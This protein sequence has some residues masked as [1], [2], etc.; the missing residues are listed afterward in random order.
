[1]S[2]PV[3]RVASVP[4]A[5]IAPF[6]AP[7]RPAQ[8]GGAQSVVA[9]LGRALSEAGEDVEVIASARSRVAG[10]PLHR[11][12]CG[13]FPTATLRFTADGRAA[14]ERGNDVDPQEIAFDSAVARMR[15]RGGLYHSH[16]FDAAAFAVPSRRGVFALHTL[17]LGPID[18]GVVAAAVAASRSAAPAR[19]VAV[20]ASV[21]EAW[22]THL[23]IAAVVPNGADPDRIPAGGGR[24]R[25]RAVVAGRISREKGTDV[26]IAAA[27]RAG[28]RVLLVGDVYDDD[29]WKEVVAPLVDGDS[30]RHLSARARSQLYRIIGA[31]AVSICAPRWDEPFGMVAL[32]SAMTGTPVA[33]LARGGLREL[34]G[35]SSGRLADGTDADALA[36]A[37]T[38]AAGLDR[39]L[40]RADV[41]QRYSM[42]AMV[43]RYRAVYAGM[44]V[45]PPAPQ[46]TR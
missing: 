19:L 13:P 16:A 41:V 33:A 3:H 34:V 1:M 17:H 29:Y 28:M 9:D 39:T 2:A 45:L 18:S 6:V 27:L 46:E 40:V 11:I 37:V 38:A 12:D 24:H 32:E 7:L 5:L 8:V 20:S 21:A 42:E 26:A 10:V 25:D 15:Q 31:S 35:P 4:I 23:D 14:G 36:V 30:V 43:A 44:P 22:R